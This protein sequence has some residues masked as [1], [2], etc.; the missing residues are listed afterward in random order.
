VDTL[1]EHTEVGYDSPVWD[2][3]TT[4]DSEGP[5]KFSGGPGVMLDRWT[6]PSV[7]EGMSGV[8]HVVKETWDVSPVVIP[9]SVGVCV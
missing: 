7:V 4:F 8:F 9:E 6:E 5:I 2:D 3:E 1:S